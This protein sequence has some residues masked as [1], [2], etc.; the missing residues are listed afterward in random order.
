MNQ[1]SCA[2]VPVTNMKTPDLFKKKFTILQEISSAI[3]GTDNI[4]LIANLMLDLAVSYT[5][6]EKGSLMLLNERDELYILAAKGIDQHFM[7]DYRVK[8]G[9]GIAG[10]VAMNRYPMLVE[11]VDK[12]DRF[13]G[14]KR[15]HYK[16]RSFISC[17]VVSRE[18]LLGVL[19]IN[20]KKDGTSFTADEFELLTTIANHAAIALENAFLVVE[21]KSKA[22]ELE[23][24]NKKLVETDVLKTEF[25]TRISHELRTPLNSVKGAIYHLQQSDKIP[26]TER[27][28]F[29]AIISGET[30]K[31]IK[32]VEN[33]LDFLRL[34]DETRTIKKAVINVT[35]VLKELSD[36]P[37]LKAALGRKGVTLKIKT[38]DKIT[39]VVGDRV[40]ALQLFSNMLEGVCHYLGQGDV[41]EV[42]VHEAEMVTV[43]MKLSRTIPESIMHYFY[44]TS[45]DFRAEHHEN[46]VKLYLAR[47]AAEVHRWKLTVANEEESCRITLAIPKSTKEKVEAFVNKSMDTF[48]EFISELMDL[49]ICSIMLS[50]EL[51]S[52][53][54]V[55]SARG[56]GDDIVKRT[57]IKFGDKI[58]GWVALEGKP[59]FVEDIE[60]DPRFSK[61]SIPQ[62]STKSFMS[63]PLK[64]DD[65]VIGVLNMNNKKTSVPFTVRDYYIASVLSERISQFIK[66]TYA[67]NCKKEDITKLITSFNS[68]INP[69]APAAEKT[70]PGR[71][72][73][74]PP[75]SNPAVP[76]RER[77]SNP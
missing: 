51:T 4:S 61:K 6:A 70:G 26:G 48:V 19:N 33:L 24:I 11:D 40:K 74:V 36:S 54:T 10:T 7:R 37:A 23:G 67:D 32:I 34:E 17:P 76:S 42:S 30:D 3:V 12:D 15:D 68:L 69:E 45:F 39:D 49:D 18:K 75:S 13:H 77:G 29:Q 47:T 22:A 38:H 72:N 1:R 2:I 46:R 66:L 35:D 53:L 71:S 63:F 20:D 25:I 8:M 16:T 31:L 41:I 44:D 64:I 73:P 55:K 9:E 43:S 59:L 60:T 50:D 58:A 21:L 5:N 27:E 14:K 28:E 56:L 52:E 62:Y 57:R 65:R